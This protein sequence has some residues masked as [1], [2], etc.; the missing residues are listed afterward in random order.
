MCAQCLRDLL[1]HNHQHQP[2]SY[3]SKKVTRI[4]P[5]GRMF[6]MPSECILFPK[7]IIAFKIETSFY[8]KVSQILSIFIM[9]LE[10]I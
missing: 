4:G 7:N 8:L 3:K 9:L 10:E 1:K 6:S 2:A 5:S